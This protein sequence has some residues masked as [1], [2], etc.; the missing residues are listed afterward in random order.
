MGRAHRHCKME[1]YI[2]VNFVKAPNMDTAFIIGL[3]TQCIR[4]IGRIMS[5]MG[6]VSMFGQMVANTMVNGN[7]T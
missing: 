5:F 2:K 3:I 4:G 1:L 7:K 6:K